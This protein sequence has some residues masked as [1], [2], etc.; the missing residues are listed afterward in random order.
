MNWN[1]RS[2]TE[3]LTWLGFFS[4]VFLSYYY[5]LRF[6]YKE[7]ILLIE[8]NVDVSEIY[9]KSDRHFPWYMIGFTLLGIGLGFV[10]ALC[11]AYF[12]S[13]SQSIE[14]EIVALIFISASILFGAI[15]MIVGHSLEQKMKALR[16]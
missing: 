14:E 1:I 6:R 15:G 13:K 16:G 7:R 9:K 8:K 4:A 5:Y 12:I 3:M 2:I 11:I 10:V